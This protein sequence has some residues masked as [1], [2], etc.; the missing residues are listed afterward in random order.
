MDT[1]DSQGNRDVVTGNTSPSLAAARPLYKPA[2]SKDRP[3]LSLVTPD[4]D[5]DDEELQ[6][7]AKV[8]REIEQIEG[9]DDEQV[10]V[11][12]RQR[13]QQARA[14]K[15]PRLLSLSRMQLLIVLGVAALLITLGVGAFIASR[16]R[17]T[18]VNVPVGVPSPS[19]D[20]NAVIAT[21]TGFGD[22]TAT[23][24]ATTPEATAVV[25]PPT[26]K[27]GIG[28]WVQV[29]ANSLNVREGASTS[30]KVVTALRFN[31]KAHVV[32]GPVEANGLT[33]WKID[34]FDP[35]DPA[36]TGWCAGSFLEPT[37]PPAP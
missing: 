28:G 29:S 15:R 2:T 18:G 32:E 9:P 23:V 35:A 7:T 10:A 4:F 19:V 16:P 33:W 17:D 14:K 11:T 3:P 1:T 22:P 37:T 30:A 27:I 31:T 13:I 36:R 25:A 8:T 6:D 20:A 34:Q 12:A 24:P 21:P 26:D 5:L